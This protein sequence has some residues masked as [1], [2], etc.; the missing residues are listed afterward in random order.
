MQAIDIP[1]ERVILRLSRA[2]RQVV[3]ERRDD[4]KYISQAF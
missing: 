3:G 1:V 2:W 4:P